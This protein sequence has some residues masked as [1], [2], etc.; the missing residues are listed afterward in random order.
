MKSEQAYTSF[1]N[2]LEKKLD[3]LNSFLQAKYNC[4]A[5]ISN[6]G[7]NQGIN[8]IYESYLNATKAMTVGKKTNKEPAI[9][10]YYDWFITL[11]L[12]HRELS[13]DI[14]TK[15]R[16][17]LQPLTE[18]GNYETL[19]STF[20]TYCKYN[21]NLSQTARNMYVHRNTVIYRLEK[22]SEV[23][24]L[25][26]DSFEHCLLLYMAIRCYEESSS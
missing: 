2:S 5:A 19:S 15:F 8:G 3:K 18:L 17:I 13:M 25:K 10:H 26:I 20:V 24:S 22:I 1:T 6:G 16:N 12:L 23:T 21:M 4:F 9:Y 11:E 7:M 14:K